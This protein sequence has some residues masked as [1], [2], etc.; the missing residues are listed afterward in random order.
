M[1]C[2]Q[3]TESRHG[4]M[5]CIN[6]HGVLITGAAGIGKSSLALELISQGHQLVADDV[7]DLTRTQHSLTAASPNMLKGLLH[8]RELGTINIQQQFGQQAVLESAP[9]DYLLKLS[10][11]PSGQATLDANYPE[12]NILQK[13]IPT[14]CLSVT[15]PASICSRLLI[16]LDLQQTSN[17]GNHTL[18]QRQQQDMCQ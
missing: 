12:I 4:V 1:P 17:N 18:I 13:P 2:K 8:T 15:N 11:T 6:G 10:A 14:L 7:V 3:Q 16:W 5:V 9:V